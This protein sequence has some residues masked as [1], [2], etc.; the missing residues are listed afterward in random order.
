MLTC[1]TT[2]VATNQRDTV[3]MVICCGFSEIV[4]FYLWSVS[5]FYFNMKLYNEVTQRA[6]I[7]ESE[8][9]HRESFG[10]LSVKMPVFVF[11]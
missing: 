6:S 7:Y 1:S 4:F 8:G 3:I 10:K 2:N 11:T 5:L 9:E